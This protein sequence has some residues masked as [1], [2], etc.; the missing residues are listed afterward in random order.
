MIYERRFG[1]TMFGLIEFEGGLGMRRGRREG[2]V[3]RGG[4][5]RLGG[6]ELVSWR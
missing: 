3:K 5:G 1:N 4:S 2:E 6:G